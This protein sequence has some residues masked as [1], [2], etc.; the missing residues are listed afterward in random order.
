MLLEAGPSALSD[1][2]LLRL[3][4]GTGFQKYKTSC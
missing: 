1:G 3:L 4:F 2:K